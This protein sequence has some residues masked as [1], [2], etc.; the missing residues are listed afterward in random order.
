VTEKVDKTKKEITA[1]ITE[2]LSPIQKIKDSFVAM[3]TKI[4]DF[5]SEIGN[6]FKF[7][8]FT[9]GAALGLKSAKDALATMAKEKAEKVIAE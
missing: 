3:G 4:G 7:L 2:A 8:L 1:G 6:T 5:F 9:L